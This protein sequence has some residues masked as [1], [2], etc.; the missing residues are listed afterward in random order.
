MPTER[1]TL[2]RPEIVAP[3]GDPD[4]LKTALHFGADAVYLGLKRFSLRNFAT[5]FDFDQLEWALDFAHSLNRKV[6]VTLNALPYDEDFDLI[7]E[8]VRRLGALAPDGIIVSDPGVLR[9][10]GTEAPH[11]AVHMSTQA[12]VM[13]SHAASFWAGQGVQRIVAARELSIAQLQTLSQAPVAIEVFVHGAVCISYSGRCFLSLYW[14]GRSAN[15]GEC[16]QPCRWR[17]REIEEEKRVGQHHPIMEDSHNSYFFDA[18]DLCALPVLPQLL[19][20]GPV[21][22]KIEG[23]MKSEHYVAVTTD[24][25]A[26]AARWLAQGDTSTF[27]E[28]LPRLQHEVT[29]VSNRRFSTHF[30]DSEQPDLEAYNHKG[31]RYENSDVFIG[32]VVTKGHDFIDVELKNPLRPGDTIELR[33]SGLKSAV[34]VPT[35][36]AKTDGSPVEFGRPGTTVRITGHCS[37]G[38]GAIARRVPVPETGG[39]SEGGDDA[40]R[41]S[42]SS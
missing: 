39:S 2:P 40:A 19:E 23:R 27:A 7:R 13:N 18:K 22:W 8:D 14:S 12:N 17:Y 41:G 37:C 34:M 16:T 32:K 35:L 36:F 10:L 30:L 3:A 1:S 38:V 25:Y 6:Y 33:D 9:M 21:A 11:L 20:A 15:R 29:R 42:Q 5:N 24:V 4:K 31:S 28:A 26:Q